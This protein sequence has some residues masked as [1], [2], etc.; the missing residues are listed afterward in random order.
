MTNESPDLDSE[1]AARSA[2]GTCPGGRPRQ[3]PDRA[4][5]AAGLNAHGRLRNRA[6]IERRSSRRAEQ[7][8]RTYLTLTLVST[9]ASSTIWGIDT[10][11]LLD[12]GLTV[13]EVFTA[14]ACFTA[15]MV[16]FEV[17]TGVIA[18]RF[19][20]RMSY[21]LGS[22]TLTG[23]TLLYLLMWQIH[24]PFLAWAAVSMLLGLGRT[25]FSG[26]TE[27]WL[28]DGLNASGHEGSLE[29]AFAKGQ[30]ATGVAM[31]SGT[32]T[33]GVRRRGRGLPRGGRGYTDVMMAHQCGVPQVVATMG[34]ALNARHVAPAPPVRPEGGAGLRRR[35]RRA[36]R[37]W[38]GRWKSSSRRT[39]NSPSPR[40]PRGS[41]RATCSSGRAGSR[42]FRQV[43][44][45][46]EDALDFKLT[47]CSNATPHPTSRR[48]GGSS[49]T[50]SASWPP[51]RA[52]EQA[53]PGEAGA[54]RHPARPPARAAAGDGLGPARRAARR[55]A[56]EG[57]AGDQQR[58]RGR[59]A[60]RPTP[61][62][63]RPTAAGRRRPA[64]PS[65]PSGNCS[66]CCWPTRGWCP[67]RP[68][69]SP[70]T[71]H[72]HRACGGCWRSC[73]RSTP[74]ARS[75]DLDCAAGAA[76]RPPGPVRVRP[77]KRQFVGQQMQEP[78]QWLG[79]DPEAV[80]RA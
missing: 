39:W 1:A 9:F 22:A 32:V 56:A 34:T 5:R 74:P 72:A 66:S 23:A 11:F 44:T 63:T 75:P 16:L 38:T 21:L 33:G 47:G 68:P 12:A 19:G 54:D 20:R 10:L 4:G 73:T 62:M 60:C 53:S 29:S 40:C 48:P 41:T 3:L 78:E 76:A 79:A 55:A 15:G 42:R 28:V 69:R 8:L 59:A 37:A 65:R 18:D 51:P 43:L 70:R 57:T 6:R 13:A 24:A 31:L 14:N 45:A 71:S 25:F 52:A 35:R 49:T 26:A 2:H 30:I 50:S 67:R 77:M 61:A 36:D 27:A 64:R 46:A 7:M 80:R 58:R 17:P